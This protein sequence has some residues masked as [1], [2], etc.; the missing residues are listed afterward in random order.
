MNTSKPVSL[1]FGLFLIFF[2]GA[3]LLLNTGFSFFGMHIAS[4]RL[5]P[6]FV[7]GAGLVMAVAPFLVRNRPGLGGL[8]IPA[9]PILATGALLCAGSL[10]QAWH[11]W[12]Y[13]WPLEIISLALGFVFFAI[14]SRNI[15]LLIPALYIGA[16]G[17]VLQFCAITGWWTS[18]AMLWTVEPLC[19][20]LMMLLIAF[21]TRSV[22]VMTV[23]LVISAFSLLAAA[24]M[25][26]LVVAGG[27]WQF[28]S[29]LGAVCFIVAGAGLLLMG[30]K[31]AVDASPVQPS[32]PTESH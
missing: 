5:W 22:V 13:L 20:G 24:S 28:A 27:Y 25:S 4:W 29:S 3:A 23:G 6:L 26:A 1:I 19:V 14:Y 31:K 16:N 7:L 10:F 18:W 11:V 32:Q 9:L 17:I 30:N 12:G 8:F 21:K 2:G 15:W